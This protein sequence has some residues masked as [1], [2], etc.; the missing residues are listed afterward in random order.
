[1]KKLLIGLVCFLCLANSC[2]AETVSFNVKTLKIHNS[3][4]RY[5]NC[6]ACIKI[7][8][9]E[10]IKRGGKPCKVCGG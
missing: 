1:M 7:D 4:C 8:R 9:K 6:K 2:L 5:F 3:N 10:A